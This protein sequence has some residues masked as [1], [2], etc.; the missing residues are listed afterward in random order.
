MKISATTETS[1]TSISLHG[2][3]QMRAEARFIREVDFSTV[4][5][6]KAGDRPYLS[7]ISMFI[8]GDCHAEKAARLAAAINDIFGEANLP[9]KQVAAE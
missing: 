2:C 6:F 8:S 9:I 5:L 3:E 4:W 7:D 1:V